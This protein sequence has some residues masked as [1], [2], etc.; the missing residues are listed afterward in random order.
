MK[1]KIINFRLIHPVFLCLYYDLGSIFLHVWIRLS[2]SET[3]K[4][5]S[6]RFL[7][8]IPEYLGGLGFEDEILKK[9]TNTQTYN[10]QPVIR[11][12]YLSIQQ[13]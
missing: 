7:Q 9:F 11:K 5:K 2:A 10:R 6:S 1:N 3:Q 13:K 8:I 4:F 12:A